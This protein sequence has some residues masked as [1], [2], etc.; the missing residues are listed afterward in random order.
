MK[1]GCAAERGRKMGACQHHGRETTGT[2]PVG[3]PQWLSL[4]LRL[5]PIKTQPEHRHRNDVP[6][7]INNH[8]GYTLWNCVC[9]FVH[10]LC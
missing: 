3:H 7:E 4:P 1:Q 6:S 10:I 5:P 8:N 9:G 2:A